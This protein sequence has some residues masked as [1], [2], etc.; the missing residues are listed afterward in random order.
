MSSEVED[1]LDRVLG[2]PTTCPHGNPIPGS[3]YAAPNTV[4]A[5]A[6]RRRQFTVS[7]HRRASSSPPACLTS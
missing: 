2:S 5:R 4:V 3:Q 1:A 7:H 6:R